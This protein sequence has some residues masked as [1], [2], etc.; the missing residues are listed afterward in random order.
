MIFADSEG[1]FVLS[2]L[3]IAAIGIAASAVIGA[4]I[5]AFSAYTSGTSIA[6]GAIGGA[7]AGLGLGMGIG[8]AIIAG[9]ITVAAPALLVGA[10]AIGAGALGGAI[11]SFVEGIFNNNID[12]GDIL[13]DSV[14]NGL[15]TFVGGGLSGM[16]G[17]AFIK[18]GSIVADSFFS[19]IF[20]HVQM[21]ISKIKDILFPAKPKY[22]W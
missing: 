12:R 16:M 22:A 5:G 14:L 4:G 19:W 21:S 2:A 20:G 18:C 15:F 8:A 1:K 9:G 10:I 17:K 6:G 13:F 11:G 7:I 3:A